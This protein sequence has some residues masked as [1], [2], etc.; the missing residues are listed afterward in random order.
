MS[1]FSLLAVVSVVFFFFFKKHDGFRIQ[2]NDVMFYRM[3]AEIK[4][5]RFLTLIILFTLIFHVNN[6]S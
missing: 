2:C 6:K 4:I 3:S 1:C 5:K